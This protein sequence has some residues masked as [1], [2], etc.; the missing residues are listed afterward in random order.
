[1]SKFSSGAELWWDNQF[2]VVDLFRSRCG[3]PVNCLR[4]EDRL[5]VIC[6]LSGIE[7]R[8]SELYLRTSPN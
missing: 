6:T 3:E 5:V 4:V 8:F 2:S 7:D 1:M